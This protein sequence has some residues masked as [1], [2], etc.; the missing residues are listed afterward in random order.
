MGLLGVLFC[1]ILVCLGIF[2]FTGLFVLIFGLE[3]FVCFSF[4]KKE[5]KVG[6][7]GDGE[8]QGG[9][10]KEDKHDQHI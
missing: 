2:C 8:D 9:V 10:G 7:A 4:S 5:H 3:V 1:F 6:R